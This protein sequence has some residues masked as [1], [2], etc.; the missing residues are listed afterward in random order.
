MPALADI[1][2]PKP[3]EKGKLVYHSGL[4]II[5]DANASEARL[6]ISQDTL[7]SIRAALAD[8]HTTPTLTERI[9]HSSP[10]TIIAGVLLFMSLSLG[11][12]WLA[13]SAN[14]RGQRVVAAALL[15]M[16]TL[17]AAAI[18]T[19]G[20]AGP[21]GYYAWKNL[22]QDL[23]AGRPTQGGVDIE[24]IPE[25]SGIKLIVPLKNKPTGDE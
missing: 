23:A 6:Q 15:V 4:Q 14:R 25:G 5:P 13:R 24:I 2:R 11:G 3:P 9:A 16:A 10:R 21:P 19:R 8:V 18:I 1:A 20:N 17:G 7:K 12:V 22:P